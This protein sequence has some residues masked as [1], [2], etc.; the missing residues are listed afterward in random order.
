M[1]ARVK[2]VLHILSILSD[3]QVK[4]A[5]QIC[6]ALESEYDIST[7]KRTIERDLNMLLDYDPNAISCEV[8][9]GQTN[10][11][12]FRGR[13]SLVPEALLSDEKT[14]L[15]LRLLK[16]H[17]FNVLP[18]NLFKQLNQLWEAVAAEAT[19]K[20]ANIG[21]YQDVIYLAEDPLYPSSPDVDEEV[22]LQLEEALINDCKVSVVFAALEGEITHNRIAPIQLIQRNQVLSL[23]A[24]K[25]EDLLILPLHLIKKVEVFNIDAR[26]LPFEPELARNVALN[27]GDSKHFTLRVAKELAEMLHCRPL[28]KLQR[29]EK[30]PH[31]NNQYIVTLTASNTPELKYWLATQQKLGLLEKL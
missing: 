18:R 15:M 8:G 20:N 21:K 24:T 23:L 22:Q 30:D 11:W 14:M 1:S 12:K 13:K 9:G 4:T 16:Q 7:S 26:D 17:A 2:R 29:I 25:E 5:R 6:E 19:F 31:N 10:Y 27:V 3:S 28:G